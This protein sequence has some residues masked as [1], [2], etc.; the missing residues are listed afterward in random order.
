MSIY[1]IVIEGSYDQA[2]VEIIKNIL[3]D[4]KEIIS[5]PCGGKTQLMNTFRVH[6][7][8]FRFLSHGL[9]LDKVLVIRDAGGKD[10]EE[11]LERLREKI[12]GRTYPFEVK[13]IVIIQN[14]ETWLLSDEEAISRVTQSRTG[15]TVSRVTEN[16]ESIFHPKERLKTLLSGINVYYTQ[17]V[18]KEI[19]KLVDLSKIENRCQ[20]FRNFRQAVIDC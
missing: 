15:R 9:H 2:L 11:L 14:L 16:L 5:R 17:A 19:A 13:F 20:S 3:Q 7:E 10:P 4:K 6:L 8:S 18:A 12:L 1:G